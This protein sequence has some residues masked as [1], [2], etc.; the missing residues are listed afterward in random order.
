MPIYGR[1]PGISDDPLED[2]FRQDDLNTFRSNLIDLMQHGIAESQ[3]EWKFGYA[4]AEELS[5]YLKSEMNLIMDEVRKP[6]LSSYVL[7]D[8][9]LINNTLE[10]LS[11]VP[12]TRID[13]IEIHFLESADFA[14]AI[15]PV[16]LPDDTASVFIQALESTPEYIKDVYNGIPLGEGLDSLFKNGLISKGFTK[17]DN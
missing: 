14:V 7:L 15:I 2:S 5:I 10:Y 4:S 8:S 13:H 12:K 17:K 16:D 6:R 9:G 3:L 11:T 1:D